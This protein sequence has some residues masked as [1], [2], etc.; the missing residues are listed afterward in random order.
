MVRVQRAKKIEI[1]TH[2]GTG[3]R[4]RA[5]R[6]RVLAHHGYVPRASLVVP[7]VLLSTVLL[8]KLVYD[9]PDSDSIQPDGTHVM[10]ALRE[11]G[12]RLR[13]ILSGQDVEV[14][15]ARGGSSELVIQVT[16]ERAGTLWIEP[17]IPRLR[18]P[19]RFVILEEAVRVAR[20]K[21]HRTTTDGPPVMNF[22]AVPA[23]APA[24]VTVTL[25]VPSTAKIGT[26]DCQLGI[27]VQ[28]DT[29]IR[30]YDPNIGLTV[31]VR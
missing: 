17:T 30:V 27:V 28:T 12:G 11:P 19:D 22:G 25:A 9:R 20:G 24:F 13:D 23:G 8:L 16:P 10:F 26:Y 7:L 21:L 4:V 15:V 18:G 31:D 1:C 29:P 14:S 5:V 2:F 3:A 6:H